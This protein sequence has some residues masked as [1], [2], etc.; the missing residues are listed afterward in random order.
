MDERE[1]KAN[2]DEQGPTT[3]EEPTTSEGGQRAKKHK[4]KKNL[5]ITC[6]NLV[7]ICPTLI[8][9][10]GSISQELNKLSL[11]LR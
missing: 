8:P 6:N 10:L 2:R 9:S 4:Q 3:N 7:L 5:P 11:Q 1:E